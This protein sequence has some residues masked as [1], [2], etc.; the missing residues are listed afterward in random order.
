MIVVPLR[1]SVP[2]LVEPA[3]KASVPVVEAEPPVTVTT[4]PESASI[5]LAVDKPLPAVETVTSVALICDPV[6]VAKRPKEP[7]PV[8]AT[9]PPF[10]VTT[11]PV[12]A[13]TPFAKFPCV[14][15]LRFCTVID[16]ATVP[17]SPEAEPVA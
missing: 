1:L 2:P 9:E 6:P 3:T 8:T 5:A 7:V 4:A 14:V 17:P 11:P 16:D 12:S 10:N 15:M 13:C